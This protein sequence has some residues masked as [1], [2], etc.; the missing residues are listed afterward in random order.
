VVFQRGERGLNPKVNQLVTLAA[1]ARHEIVV[2][3]DSNVCA[4][5]GYLA[6]IAGYFERPEVG[7]VTHPVTGRGELT[8]GAWMDNVHQSSGIAPGMIASTR[9][10]TFPIVVGKSMALRRTDLSALG[11]FESVKDVLAEDFVL[12]LRVR[13]ELKKTVVVA[14]R[15]IMG[16]S[17]R[18]SV[19]SFLLRNA[20]WGT[21]QRH[22]VGSTLYVALLLQHPLV[23][24]ALAAL[25]LGTLRTWL[26]FGACWLLKALLE[27]E[28]VRRLRGVGFRARHALVLPLKDAVLLAAWVLGLLRNHVT[29]RGTRLSVVERTRLVPVA[30][31]RIGAWVGTALAPVVRRL[32]G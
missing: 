14:H 25:A 13:E 3:S 7:L 22:S 8:L 28:A 27:N 11:G 9:F 32:A 2:V 19:K 31:S 18:R 21:I 15:S 24:A 10:L 17:Q 29:W 1:R 6:D 12:G 5:P 20:R 26:A 16:V 30:P 4:T 23:F